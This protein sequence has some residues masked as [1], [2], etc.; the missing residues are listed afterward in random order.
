MCFVQN[1]STVKTTP[2]QKWLQEGRSSGSRIK[3]SWEFATSQAW[4]SYSGLLDVSAKI[5]G[6]KRVNNA[7][8]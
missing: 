7:D 6:S 1:Q 4:E 5:I 2:S 8:I 3:G